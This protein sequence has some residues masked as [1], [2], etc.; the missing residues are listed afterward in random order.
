[1]ITYKRP[2]TIWQNKHIAIIQHIALIQT[3]NERSSELANAGFHGKQG[4]S[5]GPNCFPNTDKK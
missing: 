5:D 3:K 2:T 4:Q 1:M